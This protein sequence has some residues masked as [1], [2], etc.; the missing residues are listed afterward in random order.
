MTPLV[1]TLVMAAVAVGVPASAFAS[2]IEIPT[3]DHP[4]THHTL[5]AVANGS[6]MQD[7]SGNPES[8]LVTV[9]YY[10]QTVM[11]KVADYNKCVNDPDL[12]G[13]LTETR[14]EI[15]DMSPAEQRLVVLEHCVTAM[16]LG[17]VM[18]KAFEGVFNPIG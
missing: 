15:A 8:A 11:F 5:G 7:Y 13:T 18:T 10:N 2:T 3:F 9:P 1:V 6:K 4:N 14:P 16:Y 12:V 17:D